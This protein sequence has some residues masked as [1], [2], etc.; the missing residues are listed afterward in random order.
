[1]TP[2][3]RPMIHL[4]PKGG[5][6]NRMRA[7][8]SGVALAHDL[9]VQLDIHWVRAGDLHCRFDRLFEPIADPQP[10][11]RGRRPPV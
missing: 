11:V 9:D 3:E 8:D 6:C 2:G 10:L 4:K 5:L 7:V 1:M